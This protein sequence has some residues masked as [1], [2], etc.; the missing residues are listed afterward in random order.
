MTSLNRQEKDEVFIR[1]F[2]VGDML[3]RVSVVRSRFE[4]DSADGELAAMNG[5]YVYGVELVNET[6]GENAYAPKLTFSRRYAEGFAVICA[7][8]LVTPVTFGDIV[9]DIL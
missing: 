9:E 8:G 6:I 3:I 5:R 2:S 1:R 4:C 7:E